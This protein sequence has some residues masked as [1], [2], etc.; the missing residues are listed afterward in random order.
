MIDTRDS[1]LLTYLCGGI[2]GLS[3]E[4][5]NDWRVLAKAFLKT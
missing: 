1:A 4:A 2:N 5:C 3:N